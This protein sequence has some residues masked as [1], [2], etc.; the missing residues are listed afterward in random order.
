MVGRHVVGTSLFDCT[1]AARHLFQIYSLFQLKNDQ[2][3]VN[4]ENPEENEAN[5]GTVGPTV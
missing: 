2:S 5:T 1:K 4:F 3:F